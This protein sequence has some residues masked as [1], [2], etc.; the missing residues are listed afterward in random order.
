MSSHLNRVRDDLSYADILA[1]WDSAFYSKF[2]RMIQPPSPGGRILDIGCGVGQVVAHLIQSGFEAHGVDVAEANIAR[3]SKIS[4]RCVVY[5]GKQLP[6]PDDYFDAVGALNVLEH[7]ES[8]ESFISEAVRVCKPGGRVVLSSPNF[9]RVIGYHDYH[10]RM[11]G[12]RS[13]YRN[14]CGLIQ[15][16]RMM[17]NDPAAVCFERMTPTIKVPFTPDDDAI[18]ATNALDMK[19]FLERFGCD[20]ESVSCTD[21][22][23]HDWVEW[24]LNATPLRYGMFNALVVATKK[25]IHVAQSTP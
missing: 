23:V 16:W 5:P 10:P 4:P 13:K 21:R 7:T 8:P 6:Y 19:F 2:T 15:R 14:A 25:A 9:L 12:L 22:D 11:R 17:R 24:V 3:A 18:V 1:G 20:T